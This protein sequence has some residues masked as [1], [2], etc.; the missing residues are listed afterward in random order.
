MFALP[1]EQVGFLT[2]DVECTAATTVDVLYGEALD[3]HGWPTA[4]RQG[5]AAVDTISVR[6]GRT[7]HRF[8]NRRAFRYLAV[9][10]QGGATLRAATLHAVTAPRP[11]PVFA[12]S[13]ARYRRMH[14]VSVATAAVGRQDL[15]EDCPLREGGHYTADA[16]LQAMF[17]LAT[18]GVATTARRSVL[19]FTD[20]QDPDGM[21]PAL[22][23]SG[24]RHRI[25]DFA[26]QWPAYVDDVVRFTDDASLLA[27]AWPTL[28]R[29]MEWAHD[30][31]P[32]G[33]F[34]LDEPGWWPFIDWAAFSTDALR[35][36]VD[37]QYAVAL[38]SAIDLAR[39]AGD[40]ARAEL[41]GARLDSVLEVLTA[42]GSV[43]Q[44]HA[45]TI[46]LCGLD[47]EVAR[48]VVAPDALDDFAPDTGY[49]MFSV[50]RAQIV[51]GH[52]DRA[53]TLLDT[54]WGGM[55]DAG[56]GTW[57]ERYSPARDV[58]ADVSLC[59]PWSAGPL[60]LLPMLALGV[61]PFARSEQ[62]SRF[63]AQDLGVTAALHTPWGLVSV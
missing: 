1:H 58:T 28:L 61:D 45:A 17:D 63:P 11:D 23:P 9:L 25:P 49:F 40:E 10:T 48:E 53:R 29:V 57:W 62:T 50:C 14:A 24:T 43:R 52:P 13:S 19:R 7:V 37:A 46:L 5:I 60:V 44:P 2:L 16:R 20:A 39:R 6:P 26:L 22:W 15:Y 32:S 35:A 54:Y 12:T 31:A 42:A 59:H 55:L 47:A 4:T 33:T 56:A 51:L 36:A 38:R 18:T 27:E 41:Y 3:E 30:C 21:L 34:D 8:W